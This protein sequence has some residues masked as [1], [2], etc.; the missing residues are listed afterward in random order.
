MVRHESTAEKMA[1]AVHLSSEAAPEN[2]FKRLPKSGGRGVRA[3]PP[4]VMIA[5]ENPLVANMMAATLTHA[6]FTTLS[7]STDAEVASLLVEVIPDVLVVDSRLADTA[8]WV[9]GRTERAGNRPRAV[10]LLVDPGAIDSRPIRID[11]TLATLNKPVA[12]E[13]LVA[14]VARLANRDRAEENTCAAERLGPLL[15]DIARQMVFLQAADAPPQA[16]ELSPSEFRL[17]RFFCSHSDRALTRAEILRGVWGATAVLE[18]RTVDV[19]VVRLRQALEPFGMASIIRTVRGVG[20]AVAAIPA[21][22]ATR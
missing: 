11:E 5:V 7:G 4:T 6:G 12:P 1:G 13:H 17:L 22:S 20:Y 16:I 2:G 14:A 15:I 10:V 21:V 9:A 8:A 3:L 19:H 18:E